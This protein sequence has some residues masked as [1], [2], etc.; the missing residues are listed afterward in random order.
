MA[1]NKPIAEELSAPCANAFEE[2]RWV[3][4]WRPEAVRYV[5][6]MMSC[7]ARTVRIRAA[8]TLA[9]LAGCSVESKGLI[10]EC[11]RSRNELVEGIAPKLVA[12]LSTG[13][14]EAIETVSIIT[15]ENHQ[16]CDM[17]RDCD[18][19]STHQR[20]TRR[21]Q[22]LVAHATHPAAQLAACACLPHS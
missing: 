8:S 7:A 17:M 11:G 5:R 4:R 2:S 6:E 3:E 14:L 15:N 12:L 18:A 16:C 21:A 22:S 10:T 20:S 13:A 9:V 1:K 19:V